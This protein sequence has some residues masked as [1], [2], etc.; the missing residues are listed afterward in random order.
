MYQERGLGACCNAEASCGNN[1][2]FR[3]MLVF[4]QLASSTSGLL[5]S[6]PLLFGLIVQC[7]QSER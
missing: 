5:A 4:L 7:Q 3:D 2:R 6:N 1:G